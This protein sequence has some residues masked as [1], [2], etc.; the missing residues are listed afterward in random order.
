MTPAKKVDIMK[1]TTL[2]RIKLGDNREL[3]IRRIP[4]GY[5]ENLIRI[6]VNLLPGGETKT[7]AVFPE[8][9]LGDVITA[10]Q[11]VQSG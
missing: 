10:L 2:R 8:S 5:D 3:R 11:A 6:G 7:G 9:Y 4:T 1:A